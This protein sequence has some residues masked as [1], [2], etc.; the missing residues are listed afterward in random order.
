MMS[1]L[2]HIGNEWENIDS[3]IFKKAKNS[4][5]SRVGVIDIGSNSVRLVVFDGAARSPA[6]FFNEKVMCGLGFD[7]EN[8]GYL[9]ANAKERALKAIIRF[10]HLCKRMNVSSLNAVAT[11][12]VREAK[13]GQSFAF[14][15]EAETGLEVRIVSDKE[16]A[17]LSTQ[18]VLL[19]WPDA[20]GIVCDLGGGSMELARL[21]KGDIHNCL[22][23]PIGVLKLMSMEGTQKRKEALIRDV[24]KDLSVKMGSKGKRLYLV[25]GTFRI[26]ARLDMER[27]NYPLLVLHEYRMQKHDVFECAK[28]IEQQNFS[29][30]KTHIS[31]TRLALI[32]ITVKILKMLVSCFEPNEIC[33]SSYGIREGVLYES[34]PQKMRKLDPLIEASKFFENQ[35]ARLPGLGMQL[36]DFVE[37]LAS[38]I[39]TQKMR[40]VKAACLL[41]DVSWRAHPDYRA[42][43]CFENVTRANL[44][45]LTHEERVFLGLALLYRYK[46]QSITRFDELIAILSPQAQREAEIL[47]KALRFGSMFAI[48]RL[49]EVVSLKWKSRKRELVLHLQKEGLA[50]FGEIAQERFE[51]LCKSLAARFSIK[52]VK[53]KK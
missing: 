43:V 6:Y 21:N 29:A 48:D 42:M 44:G 4:H 20:E 45:G 12:A 7:L 53:D 34:M 38:K 46:N 17:F 15:I 5:L 35:S 41:H 32:P 25:G 30:F 39:C 27:K 24:I 49:D 11:A 37:P 40:I 2:S 22:S 3:D 10:V 50:L 9:N 14:Q 36:Y 18:G 16:E 19:G 31:E 33:I 52:K 13:D 8:S 23:A 26:F 1:D 51:T 28:W 47:G